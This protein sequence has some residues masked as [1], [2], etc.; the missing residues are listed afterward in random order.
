MLLRL[1]D[2]IL[3]YDYAKLREAFESICLWLWTKV[4]DVE[5]VSKSLII[6]AR[7][8]KVRFAMDSALSLGEAV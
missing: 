6:R 1:R 8:K 7:I 2:S 4:L 3:A 5:T